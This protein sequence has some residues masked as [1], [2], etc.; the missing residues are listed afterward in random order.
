MMLSDKSIKYLKDPGIDVP[1]VEISAN[2][3]RHTENSFIENTRIQP[4]N[5][6]A[7]IISRLK[8]FGILIRH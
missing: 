7:K 5:K 4:Y 6:I 1:E 3:G 8:G 2:M